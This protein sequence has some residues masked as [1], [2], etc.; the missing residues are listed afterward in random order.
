[1]ADQASTNTLTGL[2]T[3]ALLLREGIRDVVISPGSRSTPLAVACMR[4]KDLKCAVILDERSAGF[5]ALGLA[6]SHSR[7]VALICTSGSAVANYLPAV[8]EASESRVPLILLTADRPPEL[9]NCQAGQSINQ[10]KIFGGF[11]CWTAE[12]PVPDGDEETFHSWSELLLEAFSTAKTQGKPVHLNCPFREPLGGERIEGL[13]DPL[14]R[15]LERS[16]RPKPLQTVELTLPDLPAYGWIIAG[17]AQPENPL[18]YVEAVDRLSVATGWPVLTDALNPCRHFSD[19]QSSAPIAHYDQLLRDSALAEQ[20][21]PSAIIQLGPLQTGKVLRK[22]LSV[23]ALPTWIVGEG[24]SGWNASKAPASYLEGSVEALTMPNTSR[25]LSEKASNLIEHEAALAKQNDV[26]LDENPEREA[27]IARTVLFATP[28]GTP[29]YVA[30]SMPVRDAEWFWPA[31]SDQRRIFFNRGAN[32]I[33]G[34][35][36]T[37]LGVAEGMDRPAVLYTGDLALLHDT[38]GFLAAKSAFGGSLTIVCVNNQGGGIFHHLPIAKEEDIF[39]RLFATPQE[40]DFQTLASA[41]GI[42]HRLAKDTAELGLI[43]ADLPAKGVQLIEIKTD[44]VKDAAFRK[45][46]FA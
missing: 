20:V 24:A 44:R 46:L 27:A 1:M 35:L 30:S 42:P 3:A 12:A 10:E 36:S 41:Y 13:K 2:L 29:I 21:K 7:P 19:R 37:A 40:V 45:A 28:K 22:C 9:R 34:T 32:G 25:P 8:V 26:S 6:R 4:E 18:A 11:A 23:W 17:P 39:E 5:F 43:L 15:I 31:N 33:D 16:S 14:L 38:N